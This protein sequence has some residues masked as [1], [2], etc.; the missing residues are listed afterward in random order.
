MALGFFG[1]GKRG[2]EIK[3]GEVAVDSQKGEGK[4]LL[5]DL[6]RLS[7]K[8]VR[9]TPNFLLQQLLGIT[10]SSHRSQGRIKDTTNEEC[11]LLCPSESIPSAC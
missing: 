4:G 2:F 6:S 10:S 11:R 1:T 5:G 3:L 7:S 9:W 8:L